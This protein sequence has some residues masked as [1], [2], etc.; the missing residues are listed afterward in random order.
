MKRTLLPLVGLILL[1]NVSFVSCDDKLI[2]K[3]NGNEE[4]D[5]GDIYVTVVDSMFSY[6]NGRLRVA[7]YNTYGQDGRNQSVIYQEFDENGDLIDDEYAVYDYSMYKPHKGYSDYE[8]TMTVDNHGLWP[9]IKEI[10]KSNGT[11]NNSTSSI[12][13]Y[14]KSNDGKWLK[15]VEQEK[16]RNS[17]V[18]KEKLTYYALYDGD[19]V[20]ISSNSST[21]QID[22]ETGRGN[23]YETESYSKDASFD[24]HDRYQ[25]YAQYVNDEI[26]KRTAFRPAESGNGQ[27]YITWASYDSLYW[28]VETRKVLSF[29]DN[30]NMIEEELTGDEINGYKLLWTYNDSN[31][32][33]KEEYFRIYDGRFVPAAVWEYCYS[34]DGLLDSVVAL[35]AF[36]DLKLPAIQYFDDY[37]RDRFD[38][39]LNNTAY[40]YQVTP[41]MEYTV[42]CLIIVDSRGLPVSE[43]LCRLKENNSWEEYSRCTLVHDA[44]GNN[45]DYLVKNLESGEWVESES[46]KRVFDAAGRMVSH[47]SQI[48]T[49]FVE[50]RYSLTVTERNEAE[51][52]YNEL[53]DVSYSRESF[54]NVE[55]YAF[56]D[57][58]SK[59][60]N[61]SSSGESFSSVIKVK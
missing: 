20:V 17:K 51:W 13:Q 55:H 14:F 1:M 43:S 27:E 49:T 47:K 7:R 5:E 38:F 42:K 18:S 4:I 40:D 10:R 59:D 8:Y 45:T 29:D 32:L 28:E 31:Q 37:G 15:R 11:G 26:W 61:T 2:E 23:Y 58:S 30:G 56:K 25:V 53:S 9:D 35:F 19:L 41:D 33:L 3:D 21:T 24:E 48:V 39:Y 46:M 36:P 50:A 44:N 54:S 12:Y 60:V 52:V 57:G 22:P 6:E 34:Q 16:E